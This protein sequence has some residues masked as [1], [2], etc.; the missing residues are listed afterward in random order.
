MKPAA[1]F[2]PGHDMPL[3]TVRCRNRHKPGA[4]FDIPLL[5]VDTE[6]QALAAARDIAQDIVLIV[7]AWSF[8]VISHQ[9]VI[10]I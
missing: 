9:S 10:E 3:W 1:A 2:R 6:A 8:A 5:E 4:W 7:D